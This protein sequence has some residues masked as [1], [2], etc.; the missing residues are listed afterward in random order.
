[1]VFKLFGVWVSGK[2]S[3]MRIAASSG[4]GCFTLIFS[5]RNCSGSMSFPRDRGCNADLGAGL[6]AKR[7][8]SH[9]VN[10]RTLRFGAAIRQAGSDAL[11]TAVPAI[12]DQIGT[13]HP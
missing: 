12:N 11:N 13:G 4:Q 2:L 1:M 6:P 3:L 7:P 5:E 10:E 8:E 9:A